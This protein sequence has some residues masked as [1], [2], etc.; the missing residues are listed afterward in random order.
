MGTLLFLIYFVGGFLFVMNKFVDNVD[1][2]EEDNTVW[3][4]LGW[5]VGVAVWF[6]LPPFKDWINFI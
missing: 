1:D 6:Y 2:D 5:L 4:I 3:W